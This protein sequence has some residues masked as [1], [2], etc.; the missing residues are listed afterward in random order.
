MKIAAIET[1]IAGNP[2]KNWLFVRL[3]TDQDGLYGIGEG[4]FEQAVA[5]Y[6]A[7]A[8]IYQAHGRPVDAAKSLVGK[9]GC[10]VP[11]SRYAEAAWR[12]DGSR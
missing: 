5:S 11:L 6:D 3:E 10:L 1:Y 4:Q 7:A 2:W 12:G 8:A 9:I